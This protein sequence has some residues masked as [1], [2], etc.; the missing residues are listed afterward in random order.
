MRE[1]NVILMD[2]GSQFD[3][4]GWLQHFKL[5]GAEGESVPG[6]LP[7]EIVNPQRAIYQSAQE[8]EGYDVELQA[9]KARLKEEF[10]EAAQQMLETWERVRGSQQA[11]SKQLVECVP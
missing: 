6:Q 9:L 4:F 7:P 2:I 10:T 1:P 3:T 8:R 5:L 11:A